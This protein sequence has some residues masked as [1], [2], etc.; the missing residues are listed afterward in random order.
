MKAFLQQE[1]DDGSEVHLVFEISGSAGFIYDCLIDCADSITVANPSKMTWIYRTAKKNDRLD[2]RKMAVL[3]SIGEVPSV[4]MPG[5]AVSRKLL[6]I[7]RAMLRD[8]ER[9]N[10]QLVNRECGK[11]ED[12]QKVA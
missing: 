11:A 2:D 8:N 4:H 7:M 12:I 6:S 10:E 5:V 9:F 3:L 1:K